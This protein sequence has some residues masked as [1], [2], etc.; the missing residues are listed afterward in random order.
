M[1]IVFSIIFF[2][3]LKCLLN[4][5]CSNSFGSVAWMGGK[6]KETADLIHF[7]MIEKDFG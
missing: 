7:W 5:F 1:V 3:N 2:A 4:Q 6:C